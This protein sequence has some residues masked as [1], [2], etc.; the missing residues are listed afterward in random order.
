MNE[1]LLLTR[2]LLSSL[3]TIGLLRRPLVVAV[4]PGG[5]AV[6]RGVARRL[7]ADLDSIHAE[8]VCVPGHDSPFGAVTADGSAVVDADEARM[9]GV[10]SDAALAAVVEQA[11]ERARRAD[12]HPHGASVDGRVVIVVDDH[13]GS[14]HAAGAVLG[15]VRAAEPSR[16]VMAASECRTAARALLAGR[17]D[18]LVVADANLKEI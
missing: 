9:A 13:P 14:G 5:D 11:R 12:R 4:A 10:A 16:L 18:I 6:A 7:G 8:P 17:A 2:R 3:S 15:Q 1:E